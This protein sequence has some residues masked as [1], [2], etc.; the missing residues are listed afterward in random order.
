[1]QV[2]ELRLFGGK[3]EQVQFVAIGNVSESLYQETDV[4]EAIINDTLKN[5]KPL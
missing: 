1:M 4:P 2:S 5:A 3:Q